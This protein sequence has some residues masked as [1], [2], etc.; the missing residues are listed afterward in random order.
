MIIETTLGGK[1]SGVV[2]LLEI[3]WTCQAAEPSGCGG[4]LNIFEMFF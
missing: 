3:S 4:F 2:S 1:T